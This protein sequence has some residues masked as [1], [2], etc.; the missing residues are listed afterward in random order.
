MKI[1]IYIK[2]LY[3]KGIC[4]GGSLNAKWIVLF[5][6]KR[7]NFVKLKNKKQKKTLENEKNNKN[8]WTNDMEVKGKEGKL[9]KE[10]F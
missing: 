4:S 5:S 1:K 3:S 9:F 7:F 2:T 8:T 10:N 6:F